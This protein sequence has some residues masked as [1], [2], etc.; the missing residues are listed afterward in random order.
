MVSSQTSL[1]NI[2]A[3][4]ATMREISANYTFAFFWTKNFV[5]LLL[6]FFCY[7][8][9]KLISFHSLNSCSISFSANY[10]RFQHL[11]H[12]WMRVVFIGFLSEFKMQEKNKTLNFLRLF[13]LL[14]LAFCEAV[15]VT[16][17]QDVDS[18]KVQFC[19]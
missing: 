18:V 11:S 15:S 2:Y 14:C 16:Q 13:A 6:F 12:F 8:E 10:F 17:F 1:W 19:M 7:S 4:C 9:N 3:K 5:M